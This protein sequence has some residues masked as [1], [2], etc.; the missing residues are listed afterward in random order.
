M[1]SSSISICGGLECWW[2]GNRDGSISQTVG[3]L[4]NIDH[5]TAS[6]SWVHNSVESVCVEFRIRTSTCNIKF[7]NCVWFVMQ[8]H[9]LKQ[10]EAETACAES[11]NKGVNENYRR[12][13]R[14]LSLSNSKHWF[15]ISFLWR[16][17]MESD[18]RSVC[19]CVSMR[20]LSCAN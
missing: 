12:Q 4:A 15:T 6:W 13:L 16:K 18:A 11:T 2:L 17:V 20:H 7:Q 5:G 8:R 3:H 1:S 9:T 14:S 19:C 10:K